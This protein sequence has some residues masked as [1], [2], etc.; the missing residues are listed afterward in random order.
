MINNITKKCLLQA[1]RDSINH[2]CTN[3]TYIPKKQLVIVND[4]V[5]NQPSGVFVTLNMDGKLR[6]CI[7]SINADRSLIDQVILHSVNAA[8]KDSRFKPVERKD[9][10]K[11]SIEVSVLTKPKP[12]KNTTE[13]DI[14]KHGIILH[15]N[16]KRSVFLPKVARDNKW[17]LGTTL[18]N[19]AVKAGLNK[20]DWKQNAS[21]FV[22]EAIEL[23]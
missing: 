13:I 12:V 6:G 9:I 22:F 23:R 5:L 1:A 10:G 11:L 3:K 16:N 18:T 4:P 8:F 15:K 7:G 2:Y 14:K 19:L 20:D 21:C 17:D